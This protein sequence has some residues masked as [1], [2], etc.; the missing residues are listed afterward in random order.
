MSSY[1][2]GRPPPLSRRERKARGDRGVIDS[3][4]PLYY[5][6]DYSAKPRSKRPEMFVLLVLAVIGLG[7]FGWARGTLNENYPDDFVKN[8]LPAMVSEQ[9][10]QVDDYNTRICPHCD[11]IGDEYEAETKKHIDWGWGPGVTTPPT[12][13]SK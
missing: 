9:Q 12:G 10:R 6:P 7:L 8:E 5:E 1:Y 2:D 11:V 13:V 4:A 3:V